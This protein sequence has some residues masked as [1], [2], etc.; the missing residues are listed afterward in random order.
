MNTKYSIA[1][2]KNLIETTKQET[3]KNIV[4]TTFNTE[5][6]EYLTQNG[7]RANGYYRRDLIIDDTK[8]EDIKVPR[9]RN[10][11]WRPAAIPKKYQRYADGENNFLDRLVKLCFSGYSY[12]KIARLLKEFNDI[13][14]SYSTLSRMVKKAKKVV[15]N[16][17]KSL[18]EEEYI[19]LYLDAKYIKMY[20]PN[21]IEKGLTLAAVGL[22]KEGEYEVLDI[23][24]VP[25]DKETAQA[26]EDLIKRLKQRGLKKIN[27][28]ITDGI[29]GIEAVVRKFLNGFL[30]QRCIIHYIRNIQSKVRKKDIKEI[31]EDF[32]QMLSCKDIKTAKEYFYK[33]FY[34]KWSSLYK[35]LVSQIEKDLDSLLSHLSLPKPLRKYVSTTNVVE[36]FIRTLSEANRRSAYFGGF[37]RVEH[38]AIYSAMEYNR[39]EHKISCHKQW[40]EFWENLEKNKKDVNFDTTF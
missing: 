19:A 17:R 23:E 37:E 32:R 26:Y 28:L 13:E 1:N 24:I 9:I 29:P 2:V 30:Y 25:T 35:R 10:S 8:I 20:S 7:G 5:R 33:R 31:L 39:Q 6:D 4:E 3:M 21:G 40:K 22:N 38:L 15:D 16:F 14:I 34:P 27:F 11:N 12:R 18:L 36:R